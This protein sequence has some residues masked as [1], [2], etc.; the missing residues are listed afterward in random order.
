[1]GGTC[2]LQAVSG[3]SLGTVLWMILPRPSSKRFL[4]TGSLMSA[5]IFSSSRNFSIAIS[6]PFFVASLP[7]VAASLAATS[8]ILLL[9]RSIRF[10]FSSRSACKIFRASWKHWYGS[11]SKGMF[12]DVASAALRRREPNV[13]VA[14]VTDCVAS[15]FVLMEL[16]SRPGGGGGAC[17]GGVFW[18]ASSFCRQ[19][20]EKALESRTDGEMK[21]EWFNGDLRAQLQDISRNCKREV[22]LDTQASGFTGKILAKLQRLPV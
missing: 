11:C 12:C 14:S 2:R 16:R 17:G 7:I 18:R 9:S 10:S 19:L 6:F 13:A 15:V 3:R 8:A 5:R 20:A 21:R 1:M 4:I 22:I